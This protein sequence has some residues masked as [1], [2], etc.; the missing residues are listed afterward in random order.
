[1]ATD[2][3][4]LEG[5][6]GG[7]NSFEIRAGFGRHRA[8][9]DPWHTIPVEVKG[10]VGFQLGFGTKVVFL[11]T[12]EEEVGIHNVLDLGVYNKYQLVSI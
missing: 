7:K 3:L 2:H 8:W 1:M 12:P 11:D 6:S 10:M 5:R 4:L 9:P